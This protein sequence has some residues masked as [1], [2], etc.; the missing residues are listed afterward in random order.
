VV[1]V[2]RKLG[3]IVTARN[4]PEGG[5]VVKIELPLKTL[6]INGGQRAA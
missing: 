2:V 5:A 1:N 6:M 3:G 4:Q